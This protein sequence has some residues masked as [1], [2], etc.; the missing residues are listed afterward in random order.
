MHLHSVVFLPV[1]TFD[2]K[3]TEV[4]GVNTYTVYT[5]QMEAKTKQIELRNRGL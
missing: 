5:V 4:C 3:T 2:D 1:N